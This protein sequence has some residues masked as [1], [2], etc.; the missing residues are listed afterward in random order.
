MACLF[1]R[2]RGVLRLKQ[3]EVVGFKSFCSRERL[4]FSGTGVAAVVGPNGCGKSNLCDAVSWV[5]GEQSAKSLRG[6]RMSDVIFS[7][8]RSR[9]PAGMAKVSLTLHD[10]D[11]DF[12]RLFA[13][14]PDLPPEQSS[15][16]I[17][18]A[19]KLFAN[20]ASQYILNGKKVRLRD[21]RD[22]FLGTGL[23]P[24][25]YAIIEQGRIGQL[26]SARPLERRAFV[27]EAA[28]VT[29]FESRRRLAELKLA[30]AQ[31]N[32]ERVHDILV[33]VGRQSR[34]LKR[35][36]DRADRHSRLRDE[37]REVQRRWFT[38]KHRQLHGR[39]EALEAETAAARERV[40]AAETAVGRLEG[41]LAAR[42]RQ[43]NSLE[44]RLEADREEL[45][46][47][48]VALGRRR[49][50]VKQQ[51]ASVL[52]TEEATQ[53]GEQELRALVGDTERLDRDVEQRRADASRLEREAGE[54]RGLLQQ[55]ESDCAAQ[56]A[57]ID[58]LAES[59]EK[60]RREM[61]AALDARSDAEGALGRFEATL[62]GHASSMEK[63]KAALRNASEAL[64]KASS[65]RRAL[66]VQSS[67]LAKSVEAK[68]DAVE[69]LRRSLQDARAEI[70]R[71]ISER[72]AQGADVSRLVARR[73]SIEGV[74][75]HR[76]YSAETVKDIFEA[77]GKFPDE[78]RFRPLGVLADYLDVEPDYARAVEQ[79]LGEDLEQ[80]V[81]GGW[82]EASRGVRMVR[83]EFG[84]RAAFVLAGAPTDGSEQAC[85]QC[86][87]GATPLTEH[88]R[89]RDADG[90][91]IP[92]FVPKLSQGFVVESGA[93]AESLAESN[94]HQYFV[95][96]DG[97]WY[98]GR[99]VHGG[100][101]AVKGPLVLRQALRDL[102]PQVRKAER[103]LRATEAEIEQAREEAA[104][105]GTALDA[106]LGEL[107]R[108]EEQSFEAAHEIRQ[109]DK[110]VADH[111]RARAAASE[112]VDRLRKQR[113]QAEAG[114]RRAVDARRRLEAERARLETLHSRLAKQAAEAAERFVGMQEARALVQMSVTSTEERLRAGRAALAT[115]ESSLQ[116]H[117]QRV[118]LLHARIDSLKERNAR[119]EASKCDLGERIAE[120]EEQRRV[121]QE[122]ISEA[123]AKLG[124]CR[125]VVKVLVREVREARS[126]EASSR[127]DCAAAEVHL[128]RVEADLEHL[129]SDCSSELGDP[130]GAVASDI[131]EELEPEALHELAERRKTL[132][133]K[134][135]RLGPVNVL[136]AKE[137][138]EVSQR[139]HFLEAQQEDLLESMVNTH[140]AIG[141]LAKA[142]RV[143][144]DN[145][146][147]GINRHFRN[148]FATLFGGGTGQ[149]R[150]SDPG[151]PEE[152]GVDIVAQPP[153]KRLQSVALLSGGEK[154]LTVMALLMATF[155]YQP[156]PFCVLDEVDSQLDEANTIR[157]RG[158]IQEM[159]PET[160]FV[161]ITH[162][163]AMM[164]VAEALYGVTMAE[165]GVSQLVSVRMN[166]HMLQ[167]SR[168]PGSR[169]R[170][171]AG[172]A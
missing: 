13:G 141:E 17:E 16:E 147:E 150:L 148:T 72:E 68:R 122:S 145:A 151:N 120:G 119:L 92:G 102:G 25:H 165:A 108:L 39:R 167:G 104:L 126:A 71:L 83:E 87:P 155:R 111:T 49:E 57:S 166:G 21:V 18:V 95:L 113:A 146:L 132:H 127:E 130:L 137:Y 171:L 27:E 133:E 123:V 159:S 170:Q 63:T 74:L 88:V 64:D 131:G 118:S 129:A 79:F 114:Q 152:S 128:A 12:E 42:R 85:G 28:G 9:R 38:G 138:E 160:Q 158:L 169:G 43:E 50:R 168:G 109:A 115:A 61:V 60:C 29:R 112:E 75:R 140:E 35:Q 14:R 4:R 67:S 40:A 121:I 149:L 70:E 124:A 23:G 44:F 107:R 80:V 37:L 144:F 62:A 161:V 11:G 48:R 3:I 22:L 163:K 78:R 6:G 69:V 157:L 34:S 82:E 77:A 136:A 162:S 26:L 153:G 156:S 125:D 46:S 73:D 110:L 36:A 66:G 93:Q 33:E 54:Q 143:R 10:S 41:Q 19:R 55:R 105:H 154:S 97:T 86:P 76:A 1:A 2:A 142:S 81:V 172:V 89:V 51:S 135:D 15:G 47:V 59:A 96:S 84:G 5:L 56:Q 106:A 117:R 99:T 58:R 24:N 31:L 91:A 45:A 139:K 98:H 30:N 94:P 101:G 32:L 20:G 103:A 100:N 8:T 90:G 53:Q 164:A 134:I 7:G 52:E 116:E 65:R